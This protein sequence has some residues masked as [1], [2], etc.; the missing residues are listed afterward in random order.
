MTEE[1]LKFIEENALGGH[2]KELI[3]EVRRLREVLERRDE[4]L[5]AEVKNG[6]FLRALLREARE[7]FALMAEGEDDDAF[8]YM[9][10]SLRMFKR[11]DAVLGEK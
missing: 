4:Q 7:E 10:M 5:L 6:Q 2:C 9:R 1:R 11:I 3:A 8:L